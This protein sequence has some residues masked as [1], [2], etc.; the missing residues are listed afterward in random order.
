MEKISRRVVSQTTQKE[1]IQKMEKIARLSGHVGVIKPSHMLKISELRDV[2]HPYHE[3]AFHILTIKVLEDG[4]MPF[5]TIDIFSEDKLVTI[6]LA[7]L[8]LSKK[9]KSY[10]NSLNVL[11]RKYFKRVANI[12]SDKC[13]LPD[14]EIITDEPEEY[15]PTCTPG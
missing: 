8:R 10:I 2:V 5:V 12:V 4:E 13:V 3:V 6:D 1:E 11:P 9:M 14:I 7:K 15:C